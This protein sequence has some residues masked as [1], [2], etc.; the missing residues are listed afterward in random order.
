STA[1]LHGRL[2][3]AVARRRSALAQTLKFGD[4]VLHPAGYTATLRGR[5][6][7]LTLTEFKLLNCLVQHAGQACTRARLMR[8]VWDK[9]C[10]RRTVDVHVQR[11]RAKLGADYESVV[12]TVRGVGYMAVSPP[13]HRGRII[14]EPVLSTSWAS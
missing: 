4:L 12:E 13:P 14:G 11:L 5:R 6:L 8:E 1:E 10:S 3:L 9:H 2:R 7:D